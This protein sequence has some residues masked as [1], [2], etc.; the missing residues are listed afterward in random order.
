HSLP[1]LRP[2]HIHIVSQDFD[3]PALKTKRHWNSF[4]TPFFLDLLQ[5]E[6][7]LQI[8][9]KVTVR[10]EDAEALL[11]LSLR[12]HACGAVQKTIP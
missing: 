10:H 1:S 5:V 4:T 8:H 9:G 2:L 7:A 12:C 11:K 6:T 3:S